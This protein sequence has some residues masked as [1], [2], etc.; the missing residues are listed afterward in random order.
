MLDYGEGD[1]VSHMKFGEGI[2]TGIRD[3]GRDWEV[4]V[5]FEEYGTKKLFAGFAKLKKV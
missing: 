1:R 5:D 4:T 2:V 3:G